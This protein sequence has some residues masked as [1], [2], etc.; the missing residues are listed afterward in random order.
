MFPF[1]FG[2]FSHI[3]Q[4]QHTN[5]SFNPSPIHL[6]LILV[7]AL[8]LLTFYSLE[9][10]EHDLLELQSFTN[11]ENQIDVQHETDLSLKQMV[12]TLTNRIS[13]LESERIEYI[14]LKDEITI[15]REHLSEYE[16]R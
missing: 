16:K 11:L 8:N 6:L 1:Y 15:T 10:I 9:K 12:N 13:L 14:E 7:F 5:F 3:Q 2:T 4:H